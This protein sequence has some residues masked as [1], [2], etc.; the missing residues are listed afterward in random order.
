MSHLDEENKVKIAKEA[1]MQAPFLSQ[2]G[3]SFT[4]EYVD[5]SPLRG[6]SYVLVFSNSSNKRTLEISFAPQ[7]K[8]FNDVFVVFITDERKK[9]LNIPQYLRHLRLIDDKLYFRLDTY[10]GSFQEKINQFFQ[11]L[12]ASFQDERLKDILIGKKWVDLPFDWQGYK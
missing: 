1:L 4:K 10:P 12:G 2:Y 9:T 6:K 5:N 7:Y 3:F 11:F 8:Q